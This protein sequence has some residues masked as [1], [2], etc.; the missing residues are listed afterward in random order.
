MELQ[1]FDTSGAF[2][3][4]VHAHEPVWRVMDARPGLVEGD[5]L[6]QFVA[7]LE[8]EVR[9]L[10]AALPAEAPDSYAYTTVDV[11]GEQLRVPARSPRY[12]GL[13][14]ANALLEPARGALD[15]GL[16]LR[17]LAP[18]ALTAEQS[19][20]ARV[21]Q[22]ADASI[23]KRALPALVEHMLDRL[24]RT[25]TDVGVAGAL[26]RERASWSDPATLE[27]LV[28]ELEAAGLAAKGADDTVRAT[29]DLRL[30]RI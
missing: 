14:R 28:D 27:R 5:A 24:L 2:R 11:L 30:L 20:L 18:P 6:E 8:A 19:R 9:R 13:L 3:F 21:L 12:E 4:R 1:F 29:D 16:G 22:G 10:R 23:P 7:R 25:T 26:E 17:A 15:A